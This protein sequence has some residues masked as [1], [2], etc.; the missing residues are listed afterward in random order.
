MLAGRM[1]EFFCKDAGEMA[2]IFEA[3]T[4]RNIKDGFVIL[5]QPEGTLLEPGA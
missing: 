2:R 3:A 1:A 4:Q 5:R